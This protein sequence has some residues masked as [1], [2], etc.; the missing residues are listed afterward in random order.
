[1]TEQTRERAKEAKVGWLELFFDLVFVAALGLINEDLRQD[2]TIDQLG[3]V[4]IALAAL[5]IIWLAVTLISNRF[6]DDGEYRRVLVLIVMAS[7]L[8]SALSVSGAGGLDHTIAQ[9]SLAVTLV[10]IG[11]MFLPLPRQFNVPR[12]PMVMSALL[13]W[14]AAALTAG[15]AL[16]PVSAPVELLIVTIAIIVVGAVVGI[17]QERALRHR[18]A[19]QPSHLSERLG[20][21]I[22]ILLGE[23][24]VVMTITLR[25]PDAD[26]H[27]GFLI[28][29]FVM[30]FLLWHYFFDGTFNVDQA[31]LRWRS[32]TFATFLLIF[33]LVGMLDVFADLAASNLMIHSRHDL[34][35]FAI[36]SVITFL[37][38]SILTYAQRGDWSFE[39]LVQLAFTAVNLILIIWVIANDTSLSVL[40]LASSVI[41]AVNVLWVVIRR[42]LAARSQALTG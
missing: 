3:F 22:I 4:V 30:V 41:I 10:A 1:M 40:A 9:V 23:G 20:L 21:L 7:L 19:V 13:L 16:L 25:A 35:A 12:Q 32:A 17:L 24:L 36:A 42:R 8:I 37:G 6:P 5:F 15:F 38:F 11:A 34:M 26:T 33:G 29:V 39:T 2:F 18:A 31:G 14:G 27:F 28:M